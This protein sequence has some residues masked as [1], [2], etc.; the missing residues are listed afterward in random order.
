MPAVIRKP[1]T[2]R[3]IVRDKGLAKLVLPKV[4]KIITNVVQ[5]GPRVVLRSATQL[6]R[7][8]PLTRIIS[9]SSL[10]L[11]DVYLLVRQRISAHQF[12]INLVYSLTMFAGSTVGWYTGNRIASQL[13]LDVVLAFLVSLMFL[14]VGNTVADRLTRAAVSRIAETDC[15]KGLREIN[16]YCPDDL[17][18]EVTKD[19]CIEVFRQT[20][21]AKR[22]CVREIIDKAV[23]DGVAGAAAWAEA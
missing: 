9:V 16:E 21:E 20:G 18:I 15:Q 1:K 23:A 10:T 11:V 19:Q 2:L 13:A 4:S 8:N 14:L 12:L 22:R 3:E 6:L 7:V 5:L 17:H